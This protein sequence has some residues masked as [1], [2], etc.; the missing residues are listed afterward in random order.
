VSPF[1]AIPSFEDFLAGREILV[2]AVDLPGRHRAATARHAYVPP[3]RVV[4]ATD[5]EELSRHVGDRVEVVGQV[6]R[7]TRSSDT[8]TAASCLRIEFAGP[9][10]HDTCLRIC[11]EAAPLLDA[12]PSV[13]RHP[14]VCR[15]GRVYESGNLQPIPLKANKAASLKQ[16]ETHL[17]SQQSQKECELTQ[18]ST[19]KQ[20][21]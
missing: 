8:E 7:V 1:E 14:V 19:G 6:A 9:A 5:F 20:Y 13:P 12:P 11:Q 10:S 21:P 17:F 4:D 2:V 18:S 16:I 15:A 3:Y